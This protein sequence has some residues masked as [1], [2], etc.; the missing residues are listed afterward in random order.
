LDEVGCALGG[1]M[2]AVC[3][4]TANAACCRLES[5]YIPEGRS[6]SEDEEGEGFDVFDRHK[7]PEEDVDAHRDML[8]RN[9]LLIEE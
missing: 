7:M 9:Q 5:G 6:T 4:G 2:M 1:F 3:I 8:T